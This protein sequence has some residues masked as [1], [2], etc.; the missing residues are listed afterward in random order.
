MDLLHLATQTSGRDGVRRRRQATP[1]GLMMQRGVPRCY[2]PLAL[3]STVL[4]SGTLEPEYHSSN[5]SPLMTKSTTS[6]A[7]GAT[8][9]RRSTRSTTQPPATEPLPAATDVQASDPPAQAQAPPSVP[10]RAPATPPAAQPDS[11]ALHDGAEPAP[12]LAVTGEETVVPLAHPAPSTAPEEGEILPAPDASGTSPNL[13][14]QPVQSPD[15]GK[16][17]E[18]TA[19][20]PAPEPATPQPRDEDDAELQRELELAKFRSLQQPA[21]HSRDPSGPSASSATSR[22]GNDDPPASPSKRQRANTAGDANVIQSPASPT[23]HI[24]RHAFNTADG[25]APRNGATATPT[26][27]WPIQSYSVNHLLAS[28][29]DEQLAQWRRH[30]EVHGSGLLAYLSG[31]GGDPANAVANLRAAVAGQINVGVD[32]I[33]IGTEVTL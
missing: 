8:S 10:D 28:V 5:L 31:T 12:P 7:T 1:H 3:C 33:D 32:E 25:R 9:T 27:G 11:P 16:G 21:P 29:P 20:E 2:F 22:R 19:P 13:E 15:K 23:P 17:K 4:K 14:A 26:G 18:A 30:R 24:P 6:P